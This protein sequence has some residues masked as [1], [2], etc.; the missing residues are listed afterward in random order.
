MEAYYKT[1]ASASYRIQ[2]F[3]VDRSSLGKLHERIQLHDQATT[4]PPGLHTRATNIKMVVDG[5][6]PCLP[7]WDAA[8]KKGF[9]LYCKEQLPSRQMKVE[10][11]NHPRNQI[12]LFQGKQL[13][14]TSDVHDV[15]T[16]QSQIMWMN[17][18][19]ASASSN[20][21]SDIT[22]SCNVVQVLQLSRKYH[23]DDTCVYF[24]RNDD[25]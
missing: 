4:Y 12:S 23:V 3:N 11:V 8:T 7:V 20:D 22:V 17:S 15:R 14:Q 9:E 2:L 19:K 21:G 5:V 1:V 18:Q 16:F 13:I 24:K 25:I 6:Y 10:I